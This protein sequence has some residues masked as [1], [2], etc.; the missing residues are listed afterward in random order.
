MF[1]CLIIALL[2]TLIW[3]NVMYAELINAKVNPYQKTN[4]DMKNDERRGILKTLL[5]IIMSISWAIVI[6]H[7]W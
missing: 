6:I 7:C 2:S 4:D 1:F 3:I 5:V